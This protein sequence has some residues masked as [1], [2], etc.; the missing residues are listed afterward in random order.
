VSNEISI[1]LDKL[2]CK[3]TDFLQQ[4]EQQE[5]EKEDIYPLSVFSQCQRRYG[6]VKINRLNIE[7]VKALTFGKKVFLE[8]VHKSDKYSGDSG[9]ALSE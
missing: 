9:K 8:K 6:Q 2:N 3:K 7:T 1:L 5:L 4:D